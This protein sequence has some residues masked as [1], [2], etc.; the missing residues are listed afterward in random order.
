MS[1]IPDD[2]PQVLER[3]LAG[4][5]ERR[6]EQAELPIQEKMRNI[7][8]MQRISNDIRRA[9]GRDPLPEWPLEDDNEDKETTP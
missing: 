4:K 1:P 5:R 3:L 9:A 7:A 6:R 8:I 2:A